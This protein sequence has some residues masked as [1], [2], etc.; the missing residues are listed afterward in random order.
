MAS[1]IFIGISILISVLRT[2][3]I[4]CD[5]NLLLSLKDMYVTSLND[6]FFNAAGSSFKVHRG[7]SVSD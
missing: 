1:S 3:N 6:F 4:S 5:P 7:D 2:L